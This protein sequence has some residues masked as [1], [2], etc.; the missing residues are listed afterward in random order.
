MRPKK[1]KY[2]VYWP[3]S[4]LLD[5]LKSLH[6][7]DSLTLKDL[8]LKTLSLIAIT[9]SD[10]GQTLQKI[11]VNQMHFGEDAI[12]FIITDR[13][14]TTRRVLKPRVVKCISSDEPSL[15]VFLYVK[16]YLAR[17]STFRQ[18]NDS[19]LFLSWATK[20]PVTSPTL[21]RWLKQTL[22]KAKI[23]TKM[24][25][26][27]SYRGASLSSAYSKGISIREIVA[28]GDWTN[29]DTFHKHYFGHSI[30]SPVGRIILSQAQ[31]S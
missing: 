31:K 2:L 14:K 21:A 1:S 15:N 11:N 3:V 9:S 30:D 4:Q 16:E 22:F 25:S 27:H 8:T 5:Y 20:R 19:Q 7:P 24:F 17:T 23:D 26:A 10:R 13:L 12:S 6:P 18:S 28:A 29:A